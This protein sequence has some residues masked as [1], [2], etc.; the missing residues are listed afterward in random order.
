MK[1]QLIVFAM[2]ATVATSAFAGLNPIVKNAKAT[3]TTVKPE[4]KGDEDDSLHCKVRDSKTGKVVV[5]C[6]F[7][8]CS[9][10]YDSV[11]GKDNAETKDAEQNN[12]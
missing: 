9:D 5:E 12:Q 8:N 11:N 3:E 1:K 2:L 4:A 6:W 10:L 7:C